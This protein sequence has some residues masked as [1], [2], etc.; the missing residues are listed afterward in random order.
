[1]IGMSRGLQLVLATATTVALIFLG[2]QIRETP[3]RDDLDNNAR[4]TSTTTLLAAH[5]P[6]DP[7]IPEVLQMKG[8]QESPPADN[9]SSTTTLAPTTTSTQPSTTTTRTVTTTTKAPSPSITTAAEAESAFLSKIN[10]LRRSVGLGSLTMDATIRSYARAWAAKLP[11][12]FV[13]SDIESYLES[14]KTWRTIGENIAYVCDSRASLD[15]LV[16]RAFDNLNASPE[17]HANMVN[18]PFTH[19]GI[20][21]F[22]EGSCLYTTHVFVG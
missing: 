7:S 2:V 20:G 17:H 10:A 5:I 15:T 4:R 18:G 9:G 1:V 16:Q 6:G 14:Q 12:N 8:D 21:V 11:Q 13:H 22:L 3:P 19:A